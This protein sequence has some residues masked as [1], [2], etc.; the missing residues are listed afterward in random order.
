M[1]SA[2]SDDENGSSETGEDRVGSAKH[3]LL[4]VGSSSIKLWHLGTY[5]PNLPCTNVGVGGFHISDV[6]HAIARLVFPH[7]P[8][9]I[10]FYAGDNDIAAG[11][12]AGQV[13]A[14]YR[15]FVHRVRGHL[16]DARVVFISIK[17]S[18]LRR[19]LWGRMRQANQLIEEFC[20]SD[21]H[22]TYA[23][24]ATPMLDTMGSPRRDLFAPDGLHLNGEGYRL[25]TGVISP[26]V[27][28]AYSEP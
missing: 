8:K 28:R 22:L 2:R 10:I 21:P 16:P 26:I 14:S 23:D 5:F 6:N 13:L 7:E 3:G 11:K 24:V 1:A 4:F 9:V 15:E 12:T 25:W 20:R 17:P 27:E 19:S 18:I